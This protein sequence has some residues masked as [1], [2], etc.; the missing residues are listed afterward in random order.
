MPQDTEVLPDDRP[1]SRKKPAMRFRNSIQPP[2]WDSRRADNNKSDKSGKKTPV[3]ELKPRQ[4]L[5]EA[6]SVIGTNRLGNKFP[7]LNINQ[8]KESKPGKNNDKKSENDDNPENRG[9]S[10][11]AVVLRGRELVGK[12]D[13]P[14][15]DFPPLPNTLT[16]EAGAIAASND[17]GGLKQETRNEIFYGF[18]VGRWRVAAAKWLN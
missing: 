12:I 11:T 3:T 8:P 5:I 14:K 4:E 1:S 2:A 10:N 17:L 16:G 18:G 13:L 6:E 15:R 7:F 9:K